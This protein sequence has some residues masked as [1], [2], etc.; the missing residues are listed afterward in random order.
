[1]DD[2]DETEDGV[3]DS[4]T[5]DANNQGLLEFSYFEDLNVTQGYAKT[6]IWF[7]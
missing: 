6:L 5:V 7:K 1:M 2:A 4:E 3:D